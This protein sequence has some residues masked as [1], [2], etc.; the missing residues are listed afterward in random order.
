MKKGVHKV[1]ELLTALYGYKKGGEAFDRIMPLVEAFPRRPNINSSYFSEKD[2]ILITY[3]DTLNH[4][5]EPPIRTLH[6]F[7]TSRLKNVVSGI[8]FLPFFPFS[9]D[10]G[11]AVM[12][13]FNIDPELGCWNDVEDIGR[14]FTLMLDYVVNHFSS[15]SE[16]FDNY[17]AECEGFDAFAIEVDPAEN[18]SRVTRPRSLPL[19]S[20][21]RKK[22]GETVNLWTTFSADQIDFNFQ[23]LDVLEK[24]IQV[25]LHY[26]DKGASIL[27]LDAIA[28][29]VEG[30]RNLMHPFAANPCHGQTPAQHI[31]PDRTGCHHPHR[32]QCSP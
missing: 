18:L 10:D 26:I 27:R 12:D 31:G 32:N 13:F 24:M 7:L 15:K 25:L 17:L 23:S 22:N 8:H 21:Y 20:K 5:G 16:W 28:Y 14:E 30:D 11:F 4:P 19:L 3:G 1:K 9:S 6:R 2:V 29:L